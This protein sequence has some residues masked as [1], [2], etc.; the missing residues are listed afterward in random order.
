MRILNAV[1]LAL[2]LVVLAACRSTK[3]LD[4]AHQLKALADTA[5]VSVRSDCLATEF[6]AVGFLYD[7]L[8]LGSA[9]RTSPLLISWRLK[10]TH[11]VGDANRRAV[12]LN[13][14]VSD[15]TVSHTNASRA[16][17]RSLSVQPWA[18]AAFLLALFL[19][20]KYGR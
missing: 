15:S 10:R 17:P 7:S 3:A 14:F 13:S 12:H 8:N 5:A 19:L 2:L 1:T 4:S 9:T 6:C 11:V 20:I 16:V 18:V